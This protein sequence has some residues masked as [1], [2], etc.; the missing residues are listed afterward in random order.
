[1]RERM[2]GSIFH[3]WFHTRVAI[4]KIDPHLQMLR[5]D[6]PKVWSD[7]S[8]FAAISALSSESF[9]R[10]S[11]FFTVLQKKSSIPA[12]KRAFRSLAKA[13]AVSAIIRGCTYCWARICFVAS[14]LSIWG[15]DISIKIKLGDNSFAFSEAY[16]SLCTK[17]TS[18]GKSLRYFEIRNLFV[19]LSSAT[20]TNIGEMSLVANAGATFF[21]WVFCARPS[22]KVIWNVGPLPGSEWTTI[23]LSMSR[24]SWREIER[25]SSIPAAFRVVLLSACWSFQNSERCNLQERRLAM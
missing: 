20:R 22:I 6:T 5:L 17:W 4:S 11:A 10:K 9:K 18:M 13:F 24:A 14:S 12:S 16:W 15:I 19:L 3:L 8:W 7:Q 23:S 1:M 21:L 2:I 25:P